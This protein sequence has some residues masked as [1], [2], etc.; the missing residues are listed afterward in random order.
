[1]IVSETSAATRSEILREGVILC[2]RLDSADLLV[3]A[4]RAAARGVTV[5]L[6][7]R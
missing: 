5:R 2:V 6:L 1:M 4:C 7:I 3:G